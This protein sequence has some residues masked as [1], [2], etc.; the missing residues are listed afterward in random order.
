MRRA[1]PIVFALGVVAL[2]LSAL[3]ASKPRA[4]GAG[5]GDTT[6]PP[7]S[8]DSPGETAALASG[9]PLELAWI[10]PD[11]ERP[12]WARLDPGPVPTSAPP[13]ELGRE[14]FARLCTA[15]HGSEGHGDGPLAAEL[16]RPPRDLARGSIRTRR[17]RGRLT[18]DELFRTITSGA[19]EQGM[20]SFASLPP[21]DRW[22]LVGRVGELRRGHLA[23]GPV[24]AIPLPARERAPD[25]AA[26][27]R[28]FLKSCAPCHGPEGDGKGPQ[29]PGI[30]DEAGKPAPPAAFARGSI[31][32]RGGTSPEQ[33]VR[34]VL[35]GRAGTRMVPVALE[36]QELWDVASFVAG[37]A[38]RG[39]RTRRTQWATFFD[40]RRRRALANGGDVRPPVDRW[41]AAL[42]ASLEAAKKPGCLGCHEGVAAVASG[43]MALAIDACSGGDPDRGCT[44]CHEGRATARDKATA[45]A[46]LVGN[47]GSLWVTSLG[48]GCGKCHANRGALTTLHAKPLPEPVGGSLLAVVSSRTDPTGASGSNHAYRIQRALMAQETG[49][50]LLDTSE[51]GLCDRDA[52]KYTDFDLDDPDGPVPCVGSEKYKGF[53]ARAIETGHVKRLDHGEG[54]PT[55]DAALALTKNPAIAGYVDY[56]RKECARCHLWGEG[57]DSRGERRSSGCSACHVLN[58]DGGKIAGGDPTVPKDRANHPIKHELVL[59]IPEEQCNHCHTRGT[60]VRHTEPHDKVGIGCID[61]HTSIDVHGD[62]NIYPSI[63]HQLEVRC[64]D[65]HGTTTQLPWELPL[66]R[67]S[68]AEGPGPRGVQRLGATEHLLTDRGN[69]RANW[70]RENGKAV[71]VSFYDGK[72]HVTPFLRDNPALTKEQSVA[73]VASAGTASPLAHRQPKHAQLDC[74][75]CH[76][77]EA[78]RCTSCH[79]TYSRIAEAQDY[80]LSALDYD[81]RTT[82]QAQVVTKGKGTFRDKY[83]DLFDWGAPEMRLDNRGLLRPQ[84]RGCDVSLTYMGEDGTFLDW[85][86]LMNPGDEGYPPPVA[87][88]MAHEQDL[89]PRACAACHKEEGKITLPGADQQ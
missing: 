30:V 40:S 10:F 12:D 82:R 55:F 75:A 86:P 13:P 54:L 3:P 31:V 83:G 4:P 21:A 2:A 50:V 16:P 27:Q 15:C 8:S 64:E 78:P 9:E 42:S 66:G 18:A 29:A 62:G 73:I 51:A 17:S 39:E 76:S 59:A 44:V 36:D 28:A 57:I 46:G 72:K 85:T 24:D 23:W 6:A 49:K 33:I 61:C 74:T 35:L 89:K 32:F 37:L 67:L 14:L 5:G 47:P 19:P 69:V 34:T 41:D 20:P 53:I 60:L 52:P 87:P 63:R 38:R 71:L 26:G 45:H 56:F 25:E 88:T 48:L 84:V 1:I 80:L 79:I 43:R 70:M 58:D 68:K 81:P 7:G 22:A 11:R 77:S 65:C